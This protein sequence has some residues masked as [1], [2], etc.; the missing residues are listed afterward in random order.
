M[1]ATFLVEIET[2]SDTDFLT[3]AADMKEDLLLSGFDVTSCKPW[4]RDALQNALP[5]QL[6]PE[7][8]PPSM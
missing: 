5:T 4:Q 8:Q 6:P 7:V 1:K 2:G 3:I